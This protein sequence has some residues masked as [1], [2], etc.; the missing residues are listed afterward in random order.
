MTPQKKPGSF[1]I[2]CLFNVPSIIKKIVVSFSA[3]HGAKNPSFAQ[4][5][6]IST[7]PPP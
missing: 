7:P 3:E 1:I 6:F 5:S 2:K 4:R